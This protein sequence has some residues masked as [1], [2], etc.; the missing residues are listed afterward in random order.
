MDGKGRLRL[1]KDTLHYLDSEPTLTLTV[2]ADG[3]LLLWPGERTGLQVEIDAKGRL[4]VPP[5]AGLTVGVEY[6]M[7]WRR[8]AMVITPAAERDALLE[9]LRVDSAELFASLLKLGMR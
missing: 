6:F 4:C 9:R 3:H 7:Q 2:E 1:P 5:E 8:R